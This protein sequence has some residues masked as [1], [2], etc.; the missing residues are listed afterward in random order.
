MPI[1]AT[2]PP[3]EPV[4]TTHEVQVQSQTAPAR[5]RP[6]SDVGF[7]TELNP[8]ALEPAFQISRSL[9]RR[10]ARQSLGPL[11]RDLWARHRELVARVADGHDLSPVETT[12]LRR[13]QW[14]LDRLDDAEEG[15]QLDLLEAITEGQLA[16][17]REVDRVLTGIEQ[18]APQALRRRRRSKG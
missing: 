14:Q 1:S 17:S 18:G 2:A 10:L 13:I 8:Y 11:A 6:K 15:D 7:D 9:E 5:H 3:V 4:E 16:L 12:E